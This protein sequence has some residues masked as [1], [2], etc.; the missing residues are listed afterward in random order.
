[1]WGLH[2]VCFHS[3]FHF[4]EPW[5]CS[6]QNNFLF[7]ILFCSAEFLRCAFSWFVVEFFGVLPSFF[8][9]SFAHISECEINGIEIDHRQL[10]TP[11]I[12]TRS[13]QM[14]SGWALLFSSVVNHFTFCVYFCET[15]PL[16]SQQM[17]L[18]HL[19]RSWSGLR[20]AGSE[21]YFLFLS[22]SFILYFRSQKI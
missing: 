9:L 11:C 19:I 13:I 14:Q 5:Y 4:G 21:T 3:R 1:M 12:C 18:I 2:V 20:L 7:A 22:R 8:F 17:A 15:D 6:C 10:L 16:Q